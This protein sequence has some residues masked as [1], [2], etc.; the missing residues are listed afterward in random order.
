MQKKISKNFLNQQHFLRYVHDHFIVKAEYNED[1]FADIKFFE[2]SQR[3]RYKINR[4]FSLNVGVVERISEPYGYDPL[5]EWLLDNGD[6]H[7]TQLALQEGYSVEFDGE[8]G[9]TYHNPSGEEVATNVEVWEA[10]VI[11]QVLADYTERKRNELPSQWGYSV[12]AGFDYYH[13]TDD[14]WFHSWGNIIPYHLDNNGDYTYHK[15]VGGQWIDYSGGLIFGYRFNKQLG[16]FVEGKYNKYWNR[17]WH[18][19]SLGVN[20]VIF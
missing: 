11:P 8:G 6:L 5:D 14:F 20:Y 3:Y 19:F 4:K 9:A 13:F 10:V 17:E 16:V 15:F 1:G 18:N 7:Y 2:F 12:I